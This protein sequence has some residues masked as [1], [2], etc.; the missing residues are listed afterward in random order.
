MSY[1]VAQRFRLTNYTFDREFVVVTTNVSDSGR[2]E[3]SV[4]CNDP[5]TDTIGFEALVEQ[6]LF[7]SQELAKD[8]HAELLYKWNTIERGT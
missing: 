4:F 2:W 6:W 3:C 1:P 8:I 7:D 5:D